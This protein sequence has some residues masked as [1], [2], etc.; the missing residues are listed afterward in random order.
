MKEK[1][2]TAALFN[3]LNQKAD[4]LALE[5]PLISDSLQDKRAAR[6][7]DIF[8]YMHGKPFA[9]EVKS[10]EGDNWEGIKQAAYNKLHGINNSY[11]VTGKR[12][13]WEQVF[14]MLNEGIG[15]LYMPAPNVVPVPIVRIGD[16]EGEVLSRLYNRW[17]EEQRISKKYGG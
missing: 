14:A 13:T 4:I 15:C 9:F 3:K 16:T 7:I 6:R 8:A 12:P 10:D 17:K 1:Y 11:L 5:Y 2:F